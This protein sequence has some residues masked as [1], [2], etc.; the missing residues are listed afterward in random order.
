MISIGRRGVFSGVVQNMHLH[1]KHRELV[2]I[3]IKERDPVQLKM[4]AKMLANESG[5]ILVAVE[6]TSKG[7]AI[8]VYRGKN[9]A[10]PPQ[11]RPPNLL[12]K[13]LAL[14]RHIEMQKRAVYCPLCLHLD[15]SKAF[16]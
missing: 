3:I 14:K 12:T 6:K 11:L 15:I 5:G 9:Y 4:T 16:I 13:R 2:K 7:Y 1:W 8:I 10:R